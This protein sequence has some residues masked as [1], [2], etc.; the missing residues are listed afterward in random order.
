MVKIIFHV[1][2]PFDPFWSVKYLNVGQRVPIRTAHYTFLVSGHPEDT[3]YP[4]Y[5]L[6]PQRGAQLMD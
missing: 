5:V 6:S 1:V 3:K 2:P 4:Y